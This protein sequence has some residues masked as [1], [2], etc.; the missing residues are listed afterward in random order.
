MKKFSEFIESYKVWK[1]QNKADVGI[2]PYEVN[3]L[4]KMYQQELDKLKEMPFAFMIECKKRGMTI[5][6]TND[7]WLKEHR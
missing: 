1:L 7:L 4:K 5:D 3:S 6:E 2:S